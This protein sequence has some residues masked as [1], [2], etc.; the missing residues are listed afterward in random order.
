[1]QDMHDHPTLSIKNSY[2]KSLD[3]KTIVLA[4]TGSIAAV[5]TIELSRELIRRGADVYAVMTQAASWII[6][7]M[8]LHYATGHDVITSISGKVEHVNFCGQGGLA[9]LLLI[10][11]TTANTIGKIAHG[12]DD[13]PVT[14]FVTTAI[15]SQIPILLVP[16]MHGTMYAHPGVKDNI[17]KIQQW[18]IK[19]IDPRIDEGIAK[20]ASNE[21]IILEIERILSTS[22]FA[23]KKVLI[24]SGSTVESIDPI[25]ILTNR[26]SGKTGNEIALEAYRR[27][28]DVTLIHHNNLGFPKI[29]EIYVESAAHM[30]ITVMNELKKDFDIF[31]SSAAIADYTVESVNSKIKSGEEFN[32]YFK[33]TEKLLQKVRD[34]YP[35]LLIAGF[36]AET[37]ISVDELIVRAQQTM[38]KYNLNLIVANDVG[39]KGI[40]TEDN[41]VYILSQN[42]T[43]YT[44]IQGSK[45]LIASVLLD[46]IY[47][48]IRE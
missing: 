10:V 7:P 21:N 27:G 22:Q 40:G 16:A 34:V 47:M 38:H 48:L 46:H 26:A 35:N 19:L 36:K 1:M 9:D 43:D 11:P 29:N 31:I 33:P 42:I 24:T 41:D 17:K 12:I 14:T 32:L 15:G 45:K 25:R 8:A 28:A 20:V 3:G 39:S 4:V 2:S 30:T 13:T 23:K 44:H 6:N 37:H 5:K 18:G